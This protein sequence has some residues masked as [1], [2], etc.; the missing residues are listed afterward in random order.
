MAKDDTPSSRLDLRDPVPSEVLHNQRPPSGKAW[1]LEVEGLLH[2]YHH[3]DHLFLS[4]RFSRRL[5]AEQGWFENLTSHAPTVGTFYEDAL[6][7]V[8]AEVLPAS[9]TAG[10]GFVFDPQTR[11]CSKQLDMLIYDS[12][13]AAPLYRRGEFAIVTP[14]MAISHSEI[15]KTLRPTDLRSIITTF[16]RSPLGTRPGD[17]P[18]LHRVAVFAYSSR[19]STASLLDLVANE[20][21]CHVARFCALTSTGCPAKFVMYDITLPQIYFF[22]RDE[23]IETR[24]VTEPDGW[25]KLVAERYRARSD[26][27]LGAYLRQMVEYGRGLTFDE[28]DFITS[29]LRNDGE[30][31]EIASGLRLVQRI[32][33]I[34]LKSLFPK[35]EATL[36]E[37]RVA[38]KRPHTAMIPSSR[39]LSAVKGFEQFLEGKVFWLF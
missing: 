18:G 14:Q 2:L 1:L 37:F 22:D 20:L 26:N 21:R 3:E 13:R 19:S 9:L 28:R 35:D 8:V 33:M 34:K 36:K 5:H 4:D 17:F 25:F 32:P 23:C 27:G 7:A 11:S 15:K 29:P 39:D 16:L 12:T 6:R 38:G 24:L 30:L 10:T 31:R